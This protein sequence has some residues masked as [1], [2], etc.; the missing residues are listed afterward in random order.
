MHA[1]GDIVLV[2]C[3]ELGRQPTAVA[4]PVAF[5]RRAG[6]LPVCLDLAVEALDEAAEAALARAKLVAISVPMHTALRLGVRVAE[7]VEQLGAAIHVA[8]FGVYAPL[9]APYLARHGVDSVLGAEC[10][11]ALVALVESLAGGHALPEPPQR[12][13]RLSFPVPA[14][15]GL[16]PAARYTRLLIAGPD[17]VPEQRLT[18]NVESTRGCKHMCRHCPLPAVYAGRFFAVPVDIVVADALAQIAAGARHI[19]FGDPDFLNAPTHALAVARKLAAAAPGVTWDATIKVEHVLASREVF[20]ELARLGCVFVVSAFESRSDR[21]LEILAKGHVA[22]DEHE[23]LAIVRGAGISLRPTFVAFTP[24]TTRAD[25]LALC[26]FIVAEQLEA[27]VD[28]IQLALRLLVP[29]GSLLLGHGELTP[30]LGPLDEEALTYRWTHPDPAMDA[31]QLEIA[32]LVEAA[33]AANEPADETF[34]RILARAE[35]VAGDIGFV[36]RPA[37]SRRQPPPRLSEPWFC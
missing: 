27:E 15:D 12:L 8:C 32:G 11:D 22:A 14:R 36:P 24:W 2:S 23:A 19:T 30:H 29:P 10:E 6:Y 1:L 25:Y 9:H 13:R 18:G 4:W 7:R 37:T 5:L 35:R 17:Q 33:A 20:P 34:L 28:P 31:L 26:R 16:P 3:Y 21:V